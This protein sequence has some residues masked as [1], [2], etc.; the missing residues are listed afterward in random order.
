MYRDL[1]NFRNPYFSCSLAPEKEYMKVK[2]CKDGA[3][4]LSRTQRGRREK[5]LVMGAYLPN[6][7]KS[8]FSIPICF[9]SPAATIISDHQNAIDSKG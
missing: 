9:L 3:E 6:L 7:P 2:R 8:H 1:K 5:A 4:C